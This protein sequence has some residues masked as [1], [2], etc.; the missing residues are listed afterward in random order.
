MSWAADEWKAGLNQ[1]A[2]QKVEQME[3]MI[4]RLKKEAEMKQFK[5]DSLEQVM[6]KEKKR[7]VDEKSEL[8]ALKREI[9]TLSEACQE[10]EQR[11][12]KLAAELQTKD[13]HIGTQNSQIAHLKKVLDQENTKVSQMQHTIEKFEMNEIGQGDKYE[14]LV[15]DHEKLKQLNQHQTKDSAAL[16]NECNSLKV[17][18]SDLEN[19]LHA[20][21]AENLNLKSQIKDQSHMRET[22]YKHVTEEL[23]QEKERFKI[24][25]KKF[26]EEIKHLKDALEK[27]EN[28]IEK[29]Q[30]ASKSNEE[31]LANMLKSVCA[32]VQ[33]LKEASCRKVSQETQVKAQF[34]AEIRE[35]QSNLSEKEKENDQLIKDVK[36]LRDYLANSQISSE[37]LK[38]DIKNKESVL[39]QQEDNIDRLQKEIECTKRENFRLN[40]NEEQMRT[41]LSD[42]KNVKELNE[43]TQSCL[44]KVQIELVDCKEVVK[45]LEKEKETLEKK[46][47]ILEM[48]MDT[49]KSSLS[50]VC[51]ES[52]KLL[53]ANGVLKQEVE[54]LNI[55]LADK[56]KEISQLHLEMISEVS[57]SVQVYK[58]KLA[59]LEISE[60]DLKARLISEM[61]LL[62]DEIS[63][64][65]K[66]IA[67]AKLQASCITDQLQCSQN[68]VKALESSKTDLEILVKT[69]EEKIEE[70][71]LNLLEAL[72]QKEIC[73]QQVNRTNGEIVALKDCLH[74]KE[75]NVEEITVTNSKKIDDLLNVCDEKTLEIERL[76][77]ELAI[78][79]VEYCKSECSLT[80]LKQHALEL[81]A[82]I[83]E[84]EMEMET[85]KLYQGEIE[86]ER[87]RLQCQVNELLARIQALNDTF[88]AR[89]KDFLSKIADLRQ[90]RE[91]VLNVLNGKEAEIDELK[92]EISRKS[93][94]LDIIALKLEILSKENDEF[95]GRTYSMD[96]QIEQLQFT[97]KETDSLKEQYQTHIEELKSEIVHLK[98]ELSDQ[99]TTKSVKEATLE[100]AIAEHKNTI[101]AQA[102]Q[103]DHLQNVLENVK[104]DKEALEIRY[105]ETKEK[106]EQGELIIAAMEKDLNTIRFSL[107]EMKSEYYELNDKSENMLLENQ[108]LKDELYTKQA[109]LEETQTNAKLQIGELSNI[110]SSKDLEMEQLKMEL[111]HKNE[112][113]ET[114]VLKLEKLSCEKVAVEHLLSEKDKFIEGIQ[115]A[116]TE[117]EEMK[118]KLNLQIEQLISEINQLKDEISDQAMDDSVNQATLK[119]CIAELRNNIDVANEQNV[120][121][122]KELD[123]V[124]TEKEKWHTHFE[125][126]KLKSSELEINI[127]SLKQEMESC[128]FAVE[129]ISVEKMSLHNKVQTLATENLTLNDNAHLKHRE[130]EESNISLKQQVEEL[131]NIVCGKESEIEQLKLKLEHT[132]EELRIMIDFNTTKVVKDDAE[133]LLK[134]KDI[135][136]NELQF[137]LKESESLN[138]ILK[139]EIEELTSQICTLKD[140]LCDQTIDDSVRQAK[141]KQA[142]TEQQNII[143]SKIAEITNLNAE[144]EH[145]KTEKESLHL[146]LEEERV[147]SSHLQTQANELEKV[148]E[149]Y[150]LTIDELT[151]EKDRQNA[152]LSEIRRENDDLNNV[153]QAQKLDSL[154]NADLLTHKVEENENIVTRLTLN[155][156]KLETEVAQK[157]EKIETL[158]AKLSKRLQEKDDLENL[159]TNKNKLI[160]ELQFSL[161]E[162]QSCNEKY[163]VSV[164]EHISE[165]LVQKDKQ[166][167]QAVEDS[168]KQEK[169]KPTIADQQ[170][171]IDCSSLEIARLQDEL[172][173]QS[174]E[175]KQLQHLYE[176]LVNEKTN[177]DT[178]VIK[179]TAEVQELSFALETSK[180]ELF[181]HCGEIRHL[182]ETLASLKNNHHSIKIESTSL[183]ARFNQQI[184]ELQNKVDIIET[185]KKQISEGMSLVVDQY[186]C[187]LDSI[188]SLESDKEALKSC[189]LELK[190]KSH[191]LGCRFAEVDKQLDKKCNEIIN[192]EQD[193][194]T[195]KDELSK[196]LSDV[197]ILTVQKQESDNVIYDKDKIIEQTSIMLEK[198]RSEN[199]NLQRQ[200]E[201]TQ[202]IKQSLEENLCE[203]NAQINDIKSK[204]E[205]NEHD[206]ALLQSQIQKHIL[207]INSLKDTLEKMS[208]NAEQG[209]ATLRLQL[210]EITDISD[211][212]Y[213]QIKDLEVDL[214]HKNADLEKITA[215]NKSLQE[216]IQVKMFELLQVKS[217][218][219][220]INNQRVST[221]DFNRKD[222][223]C[224]EEKIC[225]LNSTVTDLTDRLSSLDNEKCNL[226]R[227]LD[228][229]QSI[230][231]GFEEQLKLLHTE[232]ASLQV[233]NQN[234]EDQ[235]KFAENRVFDT[236]NK[237]SQLQV[238]L[239]KCDFSLNMEIQKLACERDRLKEAIDE[240]ERLVQ[241]CHSQQE[242]AKLLE[243]EIKLQETEAELAK[244]KDDCNNA[245]VLI[246]KVEENNETLL[247]KYEQVNSKI[248]D[249]EANKIT[250]QTCLE[251]SQTQLELAE[252]RI[253]A[254]L[255]KIENLEKE[256]NEICKKNEMM[257]I[258]K[259]SLDT[260][261]GKYK[262]N[263][264]KVE[265][266]LSKE[267]EEVA[268]LK[269][270]VDAL[271]KE[272]TFLKDSLNSASLENISNAAMN[273]TEIKHLQSKLEISYFQFA[274]MQEENNSLKRQLD[275]NKQEKLS[276]ESTIQEN[277]ATIKHLEDEKSVLK[278]TNSK[279]CEEIVELQNKL[280][281]YKKQ[282]IALQESAQSKDINLSGN[283]TA[284]ELELVNLKS[285]VNLR[286]NELSELQIKL[287]MCATN[288]EESEN[289]SE[290]LQKKYGECECDLI[291]TTLDLCSL[292]AELEWKVMEQ[293]TELGSLKESLSDAEDKL[294][295]LCKLKNLSDINLEAA[296]LSLQEKDRQLDMLLQ[297][298]NYV[299]EQNT[300]LEQRILELHST[301]DKLKIEIK[302]LTN[303]RMCLEK[304]LDDS[305]HE[306][307]SSRANTKHLLEKLEDIEASRES[308]QYQI[309]TLTSTKEEIE[310]NLQLANVEIELKLELRNNTAD[311]SNKLDEMVRQCGIYQDRVCQLEDIKKSK[312]I[313]VC[314]LEK[315]KVRLEEVV[316]NVSKEN[317]DLQE[318]LE[319][320]G[321]QSYDH[322]NNAAKIETQI[323]HLEEQLKQ[324]RS[325]LT[326]LNHAKQIL[327]DENDKLM[328]ETDKLQKHLQKVE[329]EVIEKSTVID[330]LNT[331]Y[332]IMLL[333]RNHFEMEN[334]KQIEIVQTLKESLQ[335]MSSK[336]N[337][338]GENMCRVQIEH[339]T[340][341]ESA[342]VTLELQK[343][344]DMCSQKTN[345][346]N[347]LSADLTDATEMVK[348]LSMEKE[349]I[350][351]RLQSNNGIINNLNKKIEWYQNEMEDLQTSISSVRSEL[352]NCAK[353]RKDE[354]SELNKLQ[355]E[356]SKLEAKVKCLEGEKVELEEIIEVTDLD[357]E[358]KEL[359]IISVQEELNVTKSQVEDAQKALDSTKTD[360]VK[361]CE[362]LA[363]A[364][365]S[366]NLIQT[367]KIMLV[368]ELETRSKEV[369]DLKKKIH[370]LQVD[371]E[372]LKDA[373]ESLEFENSSI[374][375]EK[376]DLVGSLIS[377]NIECKKLESQIET[378]KQQLHKAEVIRE[379]DNEDSEQKLREECENGSCIIESLN[380]NIAELK[381]KCSKSAEIEYIFKTENESLQKKIDA[382]ENDLCC[383][384]SQ[385]TELIEVKSELQSL[386]SEMLVCRQKLATQERAKN[387]LLLQFLSL[388]DKHAA[389]E[390]QNSALKHQIEELE[391]KVCVRNKELDQLKEVNVELICS[392]EKLNNELENV[393]QQDKNL[394]SNAEKLLQL[395]AHIEQLHE[396]RIL[397]QDKL[398]AL[399]KLKISSDWTIEQ[400][401]EEIST[402]RS[403]LEIT[404]KLKSDVESYKRNELMVAELRAE[405]NLLKNNLESR[406]KELKEIRTENDN[407]AKSKEELKKTSEKW[408]S[409]CSKLN[410]QL[411]LER[412]N[413]SK[414]QEQIKT[415][416]A[417][418]EQQVQDRTEALKLEAATARSQSAEFLDKY[419]ALTCKYTL[420]ESS[421]DKL[422]QAMMN[423]QVLN[424][425]G[426]CSKLQ[427]IH[428]NCTTQKYVGR[429]IK[430]GVDVDAPV[431][432]QAVNASVIKP[433]IEHDIHKEDAL[434]GQRD[435]PS[436]A[437]RL[438]QNLGGASQHV[439][440]LA[441][442]EEIT[443]KRK[444]LLCLSRSKL[445][446]ERT[447]ELGSTMDS[448]PTKQTS[449]TVLETVTD[450]QHEEQSVDHAMSIK[451]ALMT[452]GALSAKSNQVPQYRPKGLR[453]KRNVHVSVPVLSDPEIYKRS[454]S[455]TV[456]GETGLETQ[457]DAQLLGSK[458]ASCQSYQSNLDTKQSS[459]LKYALGTISNSPV[460]KQSSRNIEDSFMASAQHM[461]NVKKS[462]KVLTQ[463][464]QGQQEENSDCKVS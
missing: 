399:E 338:C 400:L 407:N 403:D 30:S 289:K 191:E 273:G 344:Q 443:P 25:D 47:V 340:E 412:K 10:V 318:R 98:D 435:A 310:A 309:C 52:E 421:F 448:P 359:K 354:V 197:K 372:T 179:L 70:I 227:L 21:Q 330:D 302:D 93:S 416:K 366:V 307:L 1:K 100:L 154:A 285:T 199:N 457:T 392:N 455:L 207:E 355:T 463:Q 451:P 332:S 94:E 103:F 64:K 348:S 386:T 66:L 155:N 319:Y 72:K 76:K 296:D 135:Q 166:S 146:K 90:E 323:S 353:C 238:E 180:N 83:R 342:A 167:D 54:E 242:Q 387:D 118:G 283:I 178:S 9:Q 87:D 59:D 51:Q 288:L 247:Q 419:H 446:V 209:K 439:S 200:L 397:L 438:R 173:R 105:K 38:T 335:E 417:D 211:G 140:E 84:Y 6:Q 304:K 241:M 329:N 405:M 351:S 49:V 442:E 293:T 255:E 287:Q 358:G 249:A 110:V 152:I 364:E 276:V 445:K 14:K 349:D 235:L 373:I 42:L 449:M 188:V 123:H 306:I 325:D 409:R 40:Q 380:L 402:M 203:I 297:E 99:V 95:K 221:D 341:M 145:V 37:S 58:D 112:E 271:N 447:Q 229:K 333:E 385:K 253:I 251:E 279:F 429:S 82:R 45:N 410:S 324:E 317:Q 213:K 144:L 113:I 131:H 393:Q 431:H 216:E 181:N 26:T 41:K 91:E 426:N 252:V 236:E 141:L 156:E 32:E 130:L 292:K 456:K 143:D 259:E 230:I 444:K 3:D 347:K 18:I 278:F 365:D 374:E 388:E 360:Y 164:D 89:D 266:Q 121:L 314:Y 115:F 301:I 182:N 223:Q 434:G 389:I 119:Q 79:K 432:E 68:L 237:I 274:D 277:I 116:L 450:K 224:Q 50:N 75:T 195:S 305:E 183:K 165:I 128:K 464:A 124:K 28:E 294:D 34:D 280:D 175:L 162:S 48:T 185:E 408:A 35:L 11:R 222:V 27:K 313:D 189:K 202:N 337:L 101:D 194:M 433:I 311:D 177:A 398:S 356:I 427:Q 441:P 270:T 67:E 193:L 71:N 339:S 62:Q 299:K 428:D 361:V 322:E 394:Q 153:L 23:K 132:L 362:K 39:A 44:E 246:S 74:E 129:E 17:K 375:K 78:S 134:G 384:Q 102:E 414:Y 422:K 328:F 46:T 424:N 53:N 161:T 267:S 117:H 234:L 31:K 184:E 5:L 377:R 171:V 462:P 459:T 352:H 268:N 8:T 378:L 423:S 415:L 316:A 260:E 106:T 55:M 437:K 298:C 208:S 33:N 245:F 367:E 272:L 460:K 350:A 452:L 137:A 404:N 257:L 151:V 205:K 22:D 158:L 214:T 163:Q 159:V 85:K 262:D 142:I 243:C 250:S 269:S 187:A 346:M 36:L 60:K 291:K 111:H 430:S 454:V 461:S 265:L 122:S 391:K 411:L 157:S 15:A 219:D 16:R 136:I 390:K 376:T 315:E 396:E 104:L 226:H 286:E 65:D 232:L 57:N 308:L 56:D 258:E 138:E 458:S 300:A 395:E 218:V 240:K 192:M 73:M 256:N 133:S 169:F 80:D 453:P 19:Q 254:L 401:Q 20:L 275:E 127:M 379:K 139:S 114:F 148:C 108:T 327:C 343:Y 368:H 198:E 13:A 2:M 369:D 264:I 244:Y 125:K 231:V 88:N 425:S 204:A 413:A 217:D 190:Q 43:T 4:N 263:L 206:N 228:E 303:E 81:D 212:R 383:L 290:S 239:D 12:Q 172:Q 29:A 61:E 107:D 281:D 149:T 210:Q 225:N 126:E 233:R 282:L 186:R 176:L 312:E 357:R 370:S 69:L 120:L 147:R 406:E 109:L 97:L 420:L 418:I 363:E 150:R 7:V 196:A 92:C 295:S 436:E 284:M 261:V 381:D 174:D 440:S 321:H 320:T 345:E 24:M 326:I 336:L 63:G 77:M 334:K 220:Y 248:V 168:I 86:M 331:K 215:Q 96:S 382:L 160:E 371:M 170:N 201:E